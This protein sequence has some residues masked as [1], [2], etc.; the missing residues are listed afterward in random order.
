MKNIILIF[1]FL[2]VMQFI[3]SVAFAQ[4]KTETATTADTLKT[5]VLYKYDR[6]DKG[7][8]RYISIEPPT[9]ELRYD[10]PIC[11]GARVLN[12]RSFGVPVVQKCW[13]CNG[14]GYLVSNSGDEK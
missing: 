1:V 2:I 14:K 10:C 5:T 13:R 11:K 12:D 6:Y 9:P 4:N 3:T 8:N 7:G